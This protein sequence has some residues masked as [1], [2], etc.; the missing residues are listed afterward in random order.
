MLHPVRES[1]SEWVKLVIEDD[2]PGI[3]PQLKDR[4]FE[5]F[6]TTKIDVGTGLGL[7]VTREIIHRHGG[8]IGVESKSD[9]DSSGASFQ[10]LLPGA[11]GL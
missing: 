8:S 5:P 4:I 10:I 2:G 1:E 6:F 11:P 3:A 9:A 7:W